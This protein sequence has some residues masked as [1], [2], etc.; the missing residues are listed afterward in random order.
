MYD[1]K[2]LKRGIE[3]AKESIK[4][5]EEAIDKER[6]TIVEYKIMIR[7]IEEKTKDGNPS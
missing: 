4:I 6:E 5:F 1:V 3:K 7:V 2:A